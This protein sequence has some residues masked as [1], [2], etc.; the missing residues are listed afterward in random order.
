VDDGKV[1]VSRLRLQDFLVEGD[2]GVE[3]SIARSLSKL[4]VLGPC[5][6]GSAC[7]RPPSPDKPTTPINSRPLRFLGHLCVC[8]GSSETYLLVYQEVLG[9]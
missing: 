7:H 8:Q 4:S 6:G 5:V 2:D 1:V 3:K 9:Q